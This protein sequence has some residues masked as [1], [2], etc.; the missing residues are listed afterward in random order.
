MI[1]FCRYKVKLDVSDSHADAV[2]VV[3]DG[4]IQ[5]LLDTPC[6]TLVSLSKVF[7]IYT[8]YRKVFILFSYFYIC[9]YVVVDDL[10]GFHLPSRP[11]ML[12]STPLSLTNLRGG[13]CCSRLRS[14]V[15]RVLCLTDRLELRGSVTKPLLSRHLTLLVRN[16][17]LL[18]FYPCPI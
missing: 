11:K 15:V 9:C 13:R 18:R 4:D 3:F 1:F 2:F 17:L 10:F 7:I 6:S 5:N 14:V 8:S 16:A 12:A